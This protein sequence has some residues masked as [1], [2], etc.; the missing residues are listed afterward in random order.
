MNNTLLCVGLDPRVELL[1]GVARNNRHAVLGFCK[2]IVDA[3]SES[4]CAYK[5]NH[6]FFASIGLEHDLADLIE[7]IHSRHPGLPVIL[8]AKRGDIGTTAVKYAMEAF[9]RYDAD[10]V[11]VSPFLGWDA[12]EP[13]LAYENRGVFVLC[14]TSNQG[15]GWLQTQPEAKPAYQQIAERI[16]SL[17]MP[18]VGLVVGATY[19]EELRK[20]RGFAPHTFLLIPGV[21]TQ[22]ANAKDVLDAGR[23][24]DNPKILINVSRGIM[25]H[26]Q[27]A[28]FLHSV[29]TKA[30]EYASQ[31]KIVV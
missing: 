9:E 1:P 6:A 22:G 21:G 14:R 31:M 28:N 11:T 12:I 13:F 10:A 19:L 27:T 20:I 2:D 25:H 23:A 5:P 17:R 15:S 24:A 18:N 16:A 8:D 29:N 30:R 4:V 7:Y 26:D 3:T